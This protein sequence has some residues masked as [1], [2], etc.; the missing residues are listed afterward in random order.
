MTM[1]FTQATFATSLLA[2]EDYGSGGLKTPPNLRLSV[3]AVSYE[4]TEDAT[5]SNHELLPASAFYMRLLLRLSHWPVQGGLSRGHLLLCFL[6][7]LLAHTVRALWSTCFLTM[8]GMDPNW[9]ACIACTFYTLLLPLVWFYH[10]EM[11]ACGPQALRQLLQEL[12]KDGVFLRQMEA[13]AKWKI[14]VGFAFWA[15][16]WLVSGYFV[17][18]DYKDSRWMEGT[19]TG[20]VKDMD[21]MHVFMLALLPVD[22]VFGRALEHKAQFFSLYMREVHSLLVAS[23]KEFAVGVEECLASE[24][25]SKPQ[26]IYEE[27]HQI[28]CRMRT[29]MRWVNVQAHAMLAFIAQ[30]ACSAV[31][32]TAVAWYIANIQLEFI[33]II[34]AVNQLLM[35][36][37]TGLDIARPGDQYWRSIRNLDTPRT[38]FKLQVK[39]QG[40]AQGLGP[41]VDYF[42]HL[43]RT[44]AGIFMWTQL[45]KTPMV[46]QVCSTI[47]IPTIGVFFQAL[48]G[49]MAPSAS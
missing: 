33:L 43:E 13:A 16:S 19:S 26:E 14:I 1:L 5:V 36:V 39:L 25:A 17:F 12:D 38:L 49:A 44:P 2:D 41:P 37:R 10:Y 7:I 31:Y 29:H 46:A 4:M 34:Y 27:L 22:F 47:A 48:T 21:P 40:S 28:E 32:I 6:A 11:F 3:D 8:F 24:E 9:A 45:V 15:F 18:M 23:V 30:D 35:L 42:H 20:T